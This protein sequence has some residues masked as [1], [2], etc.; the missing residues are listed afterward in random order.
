MPV[1]QYSEDGIDYYFDER[2]GLVP[3]PTSP[4][5]TPAAP[6]PLMSAAPAAPAPAGGGSFPPPAPAGTGGGLALT[7][8]A[9]AYYDYVNQNTQTPEAAASFYGDLTNQ[10][11]TG[12]LN[13]AYTPFATSDILNYASARPELA[14]VWGD[15]Y[16]LLQTASGQ[17]QNLF[18]QLGVLPGATDYTD[19][20]GQFR[21]LNT[22][23]KA[24]AVAESNPGLVFNAALQGT[25]MVPYYQAL[26]AAADKNPDFAE[27]FA[28]QLDY[29][30]TIIGATQYGINELGGKGLTPGQMSIFKPLETDVLSQASEALKNAP[31]DEEGTRSAVVTDAKGVRYIVTGDNEGNFT[32]ASIPKPWGNWVPTSQYGWLQGRWDASGNPNPYTLANQPSRGFIADTFTDTVSAINDLGPIGQFAVAV[33]LN[34]MLPGA[35][36]LG[37]TLTGAAAE[38]AIART[39]GGAALGAITGGTMAALSGQSIEKGVLSGAL[40]GGVGANATGWVNKVVDSKAVANAMG[41]TLTPQQVNQTIA[42][43]FTTSAVYAAKTGSTEDLLK[44]FGNALV[45]N[46]IGAKT[47]DG[48]V[49]NFSNTFGKE[50]LNNIAKTG[51]AVTAAAVNS[52]LSGQSDAAMTS[53]IIGTLASS[54]GAATGK[55]IGESIKKAEDASIPIYA[56]APGA[57][58][59]DAG[60]NV[61][62]GGTARFAEDIA[63]AK[64]GDP[65]AAVKAPPGY[66]LMSNKDPILELKPKLVD[67]EDPYSSLVYPDG[68]YYD[69]L[70]N[71]WMKPTGEGTPNSQEIINAFKQGNLPDWKANPTDDLSDLIGVVGGAV[72]NAPSRSTAGQPA[73]NLGRVTVTD[74]REPDLGSIKVTDTREPVSDLGSVEVTDT[75]ESATTPKSTTQPSTVPAV[76]PVTPP[77]TKLQPF[78]GAGA[79]STGTALGALPGSLKE[80]SLAAGQAQEGRKIM[81]DLRQLFPQIANIDPKV[82]AML[83]GQATAPAAEQQAAPSKIPLAPEQAAA[84]AGKQATPLSGLLSL[85]GG[86]QG[87]GGFSALA[88]AGLQML[89]GGQGALPAFAEGGTVKTAHTF[90]TGKTGHYVKGHGDGQSDDIPAMLADGEYVFDADTVAA[91][92]NGSSDAGAAILDKMRENIRKHKRSAPVDKIPPKAKSPLEY[93][94]G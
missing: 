11:A 42:N 10:V 77:V 93:L 40:G 84:V 36:T 8:E 67:P 89:G 61:E 35:G 12:T 23:E 41:N 70:Q 20:F 91:L 39:V 45:A 34:A 31:T 5:P 82:L 44:N 94:K 52:K 2:G 79:T 86:R 85:L 46:G 88:S 68:S 60:G 37:A 56:Q 13:P 72:S 3:M 30:K 25:N 51:A 90:I 14:S 59:S 87:D 27:Q 48:I 65:I 1:A 50:T 21:D 78:T 4:A 75:R 71:A 29:L 22:P 58:V 9:T 53:A 32:G 83:A 55:A 6:S 69:R 24:A 66:E 43:A 54:A 81:Q 16:N 38:T 80:T 47:A 33:G 18:N 62:I 28:P 17:T 74:T 63:K 76:S 57:I 64:P 7:P 73:T 26:Q 19:V 92:G 15:N 49:N